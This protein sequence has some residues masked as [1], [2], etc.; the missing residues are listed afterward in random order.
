MP[1]PGRSHLGV[2]LIT[3]GLTDWDPLFDDLIEILKPSRNIRRLGESS[4]FVD[5]DLP[6]RVWS[7]RF[8]RVIGSKAETL[9]LPMT[10]DY[11]GTLSEKTRTWLERRLRSNGRQKPKRRRL[12]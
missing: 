10:L 1:R 7:E 2:L 5:T 4:W 9:V 8:H 3:A 12:D 11:V 6:A